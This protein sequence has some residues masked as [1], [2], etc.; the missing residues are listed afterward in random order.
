MVYELTSH[1]SSGVYIRYTNGGFILFR[2]V[3]CSFQ[4]LSMK[5]FRRQTLHFLNL[6]INRFGV[7]GNSSVLIPRLLFQLLDGGAIV[8]KCLSTAFAIYLQLQYNEM[9]LSYTRKTHPRPN[10]GRTKIPNDQE[11]VCSGFELSL[12]VWLRYKS[13]VRFLH[14]LFLPFA[15]YRALFLQKLGRVYHCLLLQITCH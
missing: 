13:A 6:E 8:W 12:A 14:N 3:L 4:V 1:P 5:I 11:P 7:F 15:L 2:I 10:K 9:Y